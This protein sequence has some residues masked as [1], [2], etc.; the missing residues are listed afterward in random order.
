MGQFTQELVNPKKSAGLS[1]RCVIHIFMV[2]HC[3]APGSLA[4]LF[5]IHSPIREGAFV[6]R[7]CCYALIP[8]LLPWFFDLTISSFIL[9][10]WFTLKAKP[11]G[12]A[13]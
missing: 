12:L 11:Y 6:T 3:S 8:Y 4:D 10:V 1:R 9:F 5:N 13:G 7:L 2:T